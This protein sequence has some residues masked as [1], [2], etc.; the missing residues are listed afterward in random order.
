[1]TQPLDGAEPLSTVALEAYFA[2][3]L[4]ADRNALISL[5]RDSGVP[6]DVLDAL[7]RLPTTD[8]YENAAALSAA[9]TDGPL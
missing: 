8:T 3:V 2:N 9:L 5:G 4:P 1:M 6:D 7:I